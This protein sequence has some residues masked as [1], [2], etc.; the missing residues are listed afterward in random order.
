M[1]FIWPS[2]AWIL[3][4][5]PHTDNI[6]KMEGAIML[7]H[8]PMQEKT[9]P[10]KGIC[11]LINAT[12]QRTACDTLYDSILTAELVGK[13]KSTFPG[14]IGM[15]ELDDWGKRLKNS[16]LIQIKNHSIVKIG[17]YNPKSMEFFLHDKFFSSGNIPKGMTVISDGKPSTAHRTMILL[18]YTSCFIFLF[19]VMILFIYFRKAPGSSY[20][21]YFNH[22]LSEDASNIC[23][24]QP[25]SFIQK[26]AVF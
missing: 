10:P 11:N 15:V 23:N 7:S 6:L 8:Y 1:N 9:R 18:V 20:P 13:L 17:N 26:K 14:K 24:I 5:T 2:Y 22:H 12:E 4:I 19:I 3:H 16:T 21:Y 25:S